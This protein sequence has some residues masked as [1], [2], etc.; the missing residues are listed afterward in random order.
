MCSEWTNA[1]SVTCTPSHECV[2]WLVE[3]IIKMEHKPVPEKAELV[4]LMQELNS[5]MVQTFYVLLK[6]GKWTVKFTVNLAK[7]Y[8]GT[9]VNFND[10]LEQALLAVRQGAN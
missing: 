9:G 10:A 8:E 5:R 7:Q 2:P 6:S 3:F 4:K 1:H